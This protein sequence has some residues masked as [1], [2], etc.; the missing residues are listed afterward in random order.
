M[1]PRKSHIRC[2][3]KA[4]CIYWKGGV[5]IGAWVS[6]RLCV[7]RHSKFDALMPPPAEALLMTEH[8]LGHQ[9][10]DQGAKTMESPANHY[11]GVFSSAS[12]GR[13]WPGL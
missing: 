8:I 13:R 12:T 1:H 3:G 9:I 5:H 7:G 6:D 11:L 2:R 4:A 10:N